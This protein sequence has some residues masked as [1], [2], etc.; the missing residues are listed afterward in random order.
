MK[1]FRYAWG[2]LEESKASP[3]HKRIIANI[4]FY[5]IMLPFVIPVVI[6]FIF[7][8]I[9]GLLKMVAFLFE[10]LGALIILRFKIETFKREFG[11]LI[12]TFLS[13][14]YL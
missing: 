7:T 12:E 4:F 3:F 14:S 5:V 10:S 8:L 6:S 1:L 11:N 2:K 9:S 13:S